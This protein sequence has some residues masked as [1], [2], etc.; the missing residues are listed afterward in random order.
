MG[1]LKYEL[2]NNTIN[3]KGYT[4]YRIIALKD[5]GDIKAG[6]FGGFVESENNLSQRGNCWIDGRAKVYRGAKV[7]YNAQIS[8]NAQILG[9]ALVNNN[10]IVRDS[11]KVY[12][13]ASINN[14]AK[15]FGHTIIHGN[16]KVFGRA[17][18]D[19]DI[20]ISGDT[21]IYGQTS[22]KNFEDIPIEISRSNQILNI[23]VLGSRNDYTTFIYSNNEIYVCC[24]C[25]TGTLD[26][27]LFQVSKTHKDN[28]H[29]TNYISA[30]KFAKEYLERNNK[31]MC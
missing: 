10:A 19:G 29:F 6:D 26:E 12:G 16:A 25:F 13:D 2:T 28:V 4:L 31:W 11:A 14:R 3:Y 15:I 22:I 8:G 7:F 17:W 9:D 20:R 18:I 1:T 30:A 27:F 5:F 24:G 21:N 23:G